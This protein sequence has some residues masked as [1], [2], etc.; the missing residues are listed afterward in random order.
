MGCDI[1]LFTEVQKN[2]NNELKWVNCDNWKINQ[3]FDP[4]EP[5]GESK[6]QIKE[7]YDD[8]NYSLFAT[9]A[10]VRD[11]SPGN[12]MIDAPRGLPEDCC[13]EIKELSEKWG[14]DGHT[15]SWFTLKELKD[16]QKEN[17]TIKHSGLVDPKNAKRL[18]D[19]LFPESW[20]Q[21]TNQP[22]YVFREWEQPCEILKPI[23]EPLE[24]R[25]RDE[26]WIF[27]KEEHPD[28]EKEIRI[29]FWF[30]N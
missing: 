15:H 20:C 10:G 13:V 19:G 17:K 11:Y 29:V 8:R 28:K 7:L 23:I 9:L 21:G 5:D 22:D 2:I 30:D 12:K 1:H 18:E 4:K 25:M 3:W 27:D 14:D 26:F 16:F 24:E 6:Y